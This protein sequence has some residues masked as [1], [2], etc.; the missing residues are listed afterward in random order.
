[1][2]GR[3]MKIT[4]GE[5]RASGICDLMVY[6]ADYRVQPFNDGQRRSLAGRCPAL[7]CRTAVRLQGLREARCRRSGALRPRQDGHGSMRF[8]ADRP[9]ADPEKGRLQ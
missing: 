3:P 6:C 9:Y 5:M 7:G 1:M 4:V 8:I 2:S